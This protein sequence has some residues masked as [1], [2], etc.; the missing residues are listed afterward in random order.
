MSESR[1]SL[2]DRSEGDDHR[3]ALISVRM[4][5]KNYLA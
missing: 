3:N 1:R 4:L 5:F 2:E